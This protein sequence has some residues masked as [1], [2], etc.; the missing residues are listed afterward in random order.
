MGEGECEEKGV[1][2]LKMKRL[3]VRSAIALPTALCSPAALAGKAKTPKMVV[4]L[5]GVGESYN[6]APLMIM[7]DA[8]LILAEELML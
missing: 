8:Y 1:K 7:Y 3:V 4:Q 2:R 5:Y 6:T